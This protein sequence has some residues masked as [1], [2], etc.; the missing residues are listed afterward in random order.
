MYPAWKKKR[1]R[2]WARRWSGRTGKDN[3]SSFVKRA[4]VIQNQFVFAPF[5]EDCG[6][7][8]CFSI[9]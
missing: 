3:H 1:W 9:K 4:V 7:I 8:N 6:G 5:R 2:S